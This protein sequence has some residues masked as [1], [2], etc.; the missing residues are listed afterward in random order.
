MLVLNNDS[1]EQDKE[2]MICSGVLGTDG[3][4]A[5]GVCG[6]CSA[7][8]DWTTKARFCVKIV[9]FFLSVFFTF[10]SYLWHSHK[11]FEWTVFEVIHSLSEIQ[12][13]ISLV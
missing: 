13:V 1:Y 8:I 5:A 9:S 7:G 4:M 11:I 3:V 2:W 10:L 6:K 12:T